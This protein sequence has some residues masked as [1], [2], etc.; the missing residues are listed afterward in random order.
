MSRRCFRVTY[1]ALPP[2]DN[3][4]REVQYRM[5][6]GQRKA[7][8]GYTKK[9]EE[10]KKD[11]RNAVVDDDDLFLEIQRFARGHRPGMVYDL[12]ILLFFPP[13]QLLNPGWL[14]K[15][16]R[17]SAPSSKVRNKKGERKA[18]SPYKSLDTFNRRKL[19]EDCLSEALDIDDRLNW[20]G[21]MRKLVSPSG[22]P[23]VCLLLTE[24]DPA[25]FGIPREYWSDD[26]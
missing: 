16:A 14:K 2:S 17:D 8:I 21:G 19:L 7:I 18:K 3:H 23:E 4:I 13:A 24:Q 12:E 6:G 25:L 1:G 11:F 10:Y 5:I 20:S 26:A 15:Y 22:E 9:A